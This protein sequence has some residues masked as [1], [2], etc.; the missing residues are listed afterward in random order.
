[1]AYIPQV[2]GSTLDFTVYVSTAPT[3]VCFY[4]D[5]VSIKVG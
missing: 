5:D 2:I 1:V 3:G 4:A